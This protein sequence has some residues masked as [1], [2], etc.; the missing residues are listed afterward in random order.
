MKCD[1]LVSALFGVTIKDVSR[2]ERFFGYYVDLLACAIRHGSC[3]YALFVAGDGGRG[4]GW[5]EGGWW[6]L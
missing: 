1:Y 2:R 5:V 6:C 3:C 4:V